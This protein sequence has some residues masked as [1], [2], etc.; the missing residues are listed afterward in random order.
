MSAKST[1][2]PF[3]ESVIEGLKSAM[4]LELPAYAKLLDTTIILDKHET[5]AELA[6]HRFNAVGWDGD[7]IANKIMAQKK[8]A[9]KVKRK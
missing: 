4:M 9:Q 3:H 5:I 2:K 6:R 7:S 8:N 1:L